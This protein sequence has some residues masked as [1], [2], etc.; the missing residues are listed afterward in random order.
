MDEI[1]AS[2]TV[3]HSTISSPFAAE[4]HADL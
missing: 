3:I 2:K 1:L 4:T